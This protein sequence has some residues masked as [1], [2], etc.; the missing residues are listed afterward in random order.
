MKSKFQKSKEKVDAF[1]NKKSIKKVNVL[2]HCKEEGSACGCSNYDKGKV[3]LVLLIDSSGSMRK[4]ARFVNEAAVAALE[5]AK[6][7]CKTEE[8]RTV[9]LFVDTAKP[10]SGNAH[11]LG[12][13]AGNFTQSHQAYLESIGVTGPFFHDVVDPT[14]SYNKEQ[15]A[16]AI[17]DVAKYFDWTPGACRSILYISDTTLEGVRSNQAANDTAKDQA[18]SIAL[19]K[20]VTVFAHRATPYQATGGMLAADCDQDYEELCTAT[21]GYAQKGG[22]PTATLYEKLIVKAICDCGEGC[23]KAEVKPLEPCIKVVWGD[24]DCDCFETNDYEVLCITV[25]NCYSN[26]TFKDFKIASLEI[27]DKNGRPVSLLP[28]G[29]PSIELIP[30]GPICFGDIPPCEKD[31]PSCLSRE[32]VIN[33]RGAKAGEYKVVLG[34]ICYEVCHEYSKDLCFKIELC[35]S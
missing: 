22:S 19:A 30:R 10:G 1:L 31:T 2:E 21:G 8:V 11:S 23:K 24:G 26:I 3:D 33:T 14:P 7:E 35:K 16:D 32:F 27:K 5:R 15:G 20:N 18:I 9:W 12:A 28:D 34:A 17:A 25:C 13:D 6:K 4:M 29:T